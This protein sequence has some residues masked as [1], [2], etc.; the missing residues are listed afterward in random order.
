MAKTQQEKELSHRLRTRIEKRFP[1]RGRFR[2]LEE[3]SSISASRWKN[4]FYGRTDAAVEMVDFWCSKFHD[5]SEFILHG[6]LE[7]AG[8]EAPFG[9]VPMLKERANRT[10]SERLTWV[11]FEWASPS[12]DQL[13]SYLEG[14]SN[15]KIS[16]DEWKQVIVHAQP[17]SAEMVAVVGEYRPH[18]IEWIIR[19]A[20]TGDGQVDPTNKQSILDWNTRMRQQ[21]DLAFS[22]FAK[23]MQQSGDLPDC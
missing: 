1:Q 22:S 19:G 21:W 2:E 3:I 20:T 8:G 17:P 9:S 6:V 18:F 15:M 11:I 7:R 12:G 16:A 14:K 10:I 4:F 13:F 5:E 23:A